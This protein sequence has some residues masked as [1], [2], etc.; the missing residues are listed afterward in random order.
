[1]DVPYGLTLRTEVRSDD[2]E[3]VSKLV[4][5]TDMFTLPEVDIA[6]ELVS[7]RLAKGDSSGYHFLI[8]EDSNGWAGYCCYG[9][10]PCTA[11]SYDMYWIVVD[12][13]RQRLRLGK[14]LLRQAEAAAHSLGGIAMYIDTSGQEKYLPTR[15][16]YESCDYELAATLPNF[17]AEGDPKLIY[18]RWLT[19]TLP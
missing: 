13:E 5:A 14:W 19:N 4:R 11:I 15:R 17:F 2:R 3:S 9:L 12:P 18:R 16:F 8:L 1:M 10:I 7:E 6:L